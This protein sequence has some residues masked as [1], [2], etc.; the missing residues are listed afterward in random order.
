MLGLDSHGFIFTLKP[1]RALHMSLGSG[2][3]RKGKTY[4]LHLSFARFSKIGWQAFG[5]VP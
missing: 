3:G 4:L 2:S 5:L 1:R